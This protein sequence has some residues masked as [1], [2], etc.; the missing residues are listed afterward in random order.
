W[1]ADA[2]MVKIARTTINNPF[3]VRK[4]RLSVTS[5]EALERRRHDHSAH[6]VSFE[7]LDAEFRPQ[8]EC[9]GREA[10]GDDCQRSDDGHARR[11]RRGQA[12]ARV[13]D[14]M[15]WIAIEAR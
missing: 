12:R 4:N 2:M 9:R 3:G 10:I 1:P 13:D 6:S 11:C 8:H 14:V 15:V 7:Q 5:H